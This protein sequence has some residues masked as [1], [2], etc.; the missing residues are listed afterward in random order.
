MHGM[1]ILSCHS[2]RHNPLLASKRIDMHSSLANVPSNSNQ[3]SH[4]NI[5]PQ[6]FQNHHLMPQ[7]HP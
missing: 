6:T 1:L 5:N 4:K 3:S 2:Q 7:Q